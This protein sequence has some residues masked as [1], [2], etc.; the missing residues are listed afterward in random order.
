MHKTSLRESC[1]L[2]LSNLEAQRKEAALSII[3]SLTPFCFVATLIGGFLSYKWF[4]IILGEFTTSEGDYNILLAGF[5]GFLFLIVPIVYHF[6]KRR[7]KAYQ[8][9]LY[10]STYFRNYKNEVVAKII[11]QFEQNLTYNADIGIPDSIFR[12]SGFP[13]FANPVAYYSSHSIFGKIGQTHVQ[14]AEVLAKQATESTR[15]GQM[16]LFR[17]VFFVADLHKK[18]NSKTIVYPDALKY[19]STLLLGKFSEE[20]SF[21]QQKFKRIKLEDAVFERYFEVYGTDQVES[22]YLLSPALMARLVNFKRKTNKDIIFSFKDSKIYF[23]IYYSSR[24]PFFRPPLF[25][26]LTHTKSLNSYI[27][28]I[29]LMLDIIQDL[30]LNSKLNQKYSNYTN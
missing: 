26:S 18:I 21:K 17:G 24:K 5:L 11:Q 6:F 2:D 16:D 12:Q 23:G 1:P 15:T 30:N 19:F 3:I 14:F 7:R 22:R 9:Y 8:N 4:F 27:A 25:R 29:E 28:D 13:L 10:D 20:N